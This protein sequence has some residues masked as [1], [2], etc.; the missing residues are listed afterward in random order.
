MLFLRSI[1]TIPDRVEPG[2]HPFNIPCLEHGLS[3]TFKTE[4]TFFVGENGSGKSTILEAIAEK[5]G[6]NLSGGNRDHQYMLDR[7]LSDLAYATTLTWNRKT[8]EG[9]FMRAETFFNFATYLE[10][11]GSTFRSYGGKSLHEQSHGESF[12]SLFANRFESGLYILDEPEAALSPARQLSFLA[13]IHDLVASGHAQFV[14]ATHSPIILSF[15]GATILNLDGDR[16]SPIEYK[17]TSHYKL[18]REFL[19]CPERYF[20]HLFADPEEE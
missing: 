2:R 3:I 5:C 9:F 18:T 17:E 16:I 11:I 7:V 1:T 15:P 13:I 10:D 19:E 14:I 6:F 8:V 12:L 4:V 20:R